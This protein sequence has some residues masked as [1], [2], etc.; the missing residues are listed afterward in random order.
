MK[1]AAIHNAASRATLVIAL[2]LPAILVNPILQAGA[3][4]GDLD[5]TF[6]TGGIVTTPIGGATNDES[7][8]VA[9]QADGKIVVLGETRDPAGSNL[10]DLA[11]IRYN[12]NGSLDSTFG[13][14]GK[15]IT[16]VSG[17]DATDRAASLVIQTDGKI[18]VGGSTR[19]SSNNYD[20]A[21]VRYN[22]DGSLDRTFGIEGKVITQVGTGNDVVGSLVVQP[23]GK[24]VVGGETDTPGA[25][26][27][28]ALV[29]YNSDGTLDGAFGSGG[30]VNTDFI[31]RY[32]AIEWLG[33]E[34]SGK[35][36][37]IGY[38]STVSGSGGFD[39]ALACY[40]SNGSLDTTFGT[41]G[42]VVLDVTGSVEADFGLSGV[43]QVDG[44]IIA[45]GYAKNGTNGNDFFLVRFNSNGAI[46]GGF[47]TNGIVLTSI[48]NGTSDW[49]YSLALQGDGKV[50]A[51]GVGNG[52]FALARYNEDGSL[53]PGFGVDGIITTPGS[54]GFGPDMIAQQSDS[55]ILAVGKISNG[56]DYDFQVV[57]YLGD[58]APSSTARFDFDGDGKTDPSVFRP[59]PGVAAKTSGPEASSSQWWVY[60][61]SDGGNLAYGFG[62]ADDV[63]VAADY[64]G[65]GKTD[66]AF[67]RP[68]D[69]TWYILRSDDL[70][71][72]A[73]PFGASGDTP[74]PGDFDGDGKADPAVFRPS[75]GTWYVLRSSDSGVSAVPFGVDG[76]R[77]TVA[78]F[79]G[80]GS[81]D[82]A[83]YRPSENQWWQLRSSEGVIAYQFGSAGD[84]TAVGDWTGDGEADV[85]FYRPATAEFYVLRSEDKT[86]YKI[87]WGLSGDVPVAGDYDGDGVTDAAVWRSAD[88]TWYILGSQS[89]S[90]TIPFGTV[91]DV[92]IP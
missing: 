85:A 3:A 59:T 86:V 47:G 82:V 34:P 60:R 8:G 23:D 42:K 77:P 33:R 52:S 18:L 17:N 89:G 63:P 92:P 75:S 53:D 73:F 65:D 83:V 57:R 41:R 11:V 68:S 46:D 87:K 39:L 16:D 4:P 56:S 44:K 35:F 15:V 58:A 29:R 80:D 88:S 61:S 70:T 50:I 66:V 26:R 36:V 45:G 48:G 62:N 38:T 24:I 6:G 10:P 69:S 64:T 7:L 76:D 21:L 43:I 2:T 1:L 51:G 79:D 9:V 81:D 20:F 49:V 72:Y 28:F 91:G 12:S 40:E 25:S 74:A 90:M 55:K 32:D 71:Y 27:D 37:A 22:S 67:F 84:M 31:G 19:N 30:K 14:G 5:P 54:P 78:D 13:S